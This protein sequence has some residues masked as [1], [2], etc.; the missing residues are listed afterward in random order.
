MGG[1]APLPCRFHN[2]DANYCTNAMNPFSLDKRVIYAPDGK[3]ISEIDLLDRSGK[4]SEIDKYSGGL[5]Q[6][7]VKYQHDGKTISEVDTYT[8]IDRH[9]ASVT[10][11]DLLSGHKL[12]T[13]LNS[14]GK[15]TEFD[16]STLD[17][18]GAVVET[19]KLSPLGIVFEADRYN[20]GHLS[21]ISTFDKS[22]ELSTTSKFASDGKSITETDTYQYGALPFHP[23][24]ES[25]ADG[26]GKVFEVDYFD[27]WG[28]VIGVDH[29]GA[30]P[31]VTIP[32]VNTPTQQSGTV[33]TPISTSGW[34]QSAGFGEIDVSK[35]LSAA[36]GM[37]V[38]DAPVPSSIKGQWDLGALHF[39]DAWAA[40]F[41]GKSVVI[42]DIDTGIDL[43]NASL[44]KN[45]SQYNWN[46]ISNSSN[47][48]DDNGHGTCTASEMIAANDGKG[49]TGAAYDAQLMVL[50][51]LDAQGSGSDSNIIAAINYAVS[52]GANVIN[53]SLG[54]STPNGNLQ[55]ALSNAS[56]HGVIV[57]MAAGN[58][59]SAT[60]DYPAGYAKNIADC[61]AV[62]ASQSS[63]SDFSMASFSNK[64]GSASSYNFVDAPGVSI[65]GYGLGGAIY[66]WQGTSMAAPLVAAEAAD[67]LSAHTSFSAAQ[68]VQDILHSTVSLVGVASMAA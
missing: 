58:D 50:K 22:G 44:T 9:L 10:Q 5:I 62:G 28:H 16:F 33:T 29:P 64:A 52:H 21:S 31:A 15:I 42:A 65:K 56:S 66:N 11:L 20:G 35:A 6:S 26:S 23:V 17:K 47:V 7:A 19:Y 49:V 39:E 36:L 61:I 54:G 24:S 53:L 12:V 40:G 1:Q 46:F 43:K 60:P 27:Y 55:A 45:L 38:Q 67:I 32:T 37:N 51:V 57:C 59:G 48:Q 68:V 18:T 3:T 34:G 8:Y 63:G 14:S 4:I 2:I 30:A 25:K 41:T 13:V